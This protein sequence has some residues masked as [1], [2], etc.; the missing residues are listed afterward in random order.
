[1]I[2]TQ[3]PNGNKIYYISGWIESIAYQYI[4]HY[5][6]HTDKVFG[7]NLHIDDICKVREQHP[8]KKAVFVN[9]EHKA[10]ID[11]NGQL[12]YCSKMWTDA[13]NKMTTDTM[14]EVWD[15]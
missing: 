1:M 15:F 7:I 9:L 11:Q 5:S 8:D 13:Y 4:E 14:H 12:N 6:K 10:P 2:D 3:M